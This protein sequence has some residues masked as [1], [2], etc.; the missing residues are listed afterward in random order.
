MHSKGLF[1]F[2]CIPV[3]AFI[4]YLAYTLSTEHLR[5]LSVGLFA[6]GVSF[7]YLYVFNKRLDAPE[8]GG[9]TWWHNLRPVHGLLYV[10]AA[11]YAFN[12]N[13]HIAASLLGLDALFGLCV[14]LA[15]HYG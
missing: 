11:I 4:A 9:I 13:N 2:G 3:R 12:G 15:H 7:L 14:F 5:Y 1:L 10:T 8:A 6:I